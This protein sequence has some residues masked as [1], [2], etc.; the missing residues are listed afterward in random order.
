MQRPQ[1]PRNS[2][3]REFRVWMNRAIKAPV[4]IASGVRSG[5]AGLISRTPSGI[6]A[7][8]SR[9]K[10]D[11][12]EL[13]PRK[14][15]LALAHYLPWEFLTELLAFASVKGCGVPPHSVRAFAQIIRG[16]RIHWPMRSLR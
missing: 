5:S 2:F 14:V 13:V 6:T 10:V 4:N 9:A 8:P 7:R 15:P 1:N 16:E 3:A 11:S 12:N